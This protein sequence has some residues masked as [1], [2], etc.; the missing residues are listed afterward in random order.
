VLR[1]A[2]FRRHKK[3]VGRVFGPSDGPYFLRACPQLFAGAPAYIHPKPAALRRYFFVEPAVPVRRPGPKIPGACDSPSRGKGLRFLFGGDH[4]SPRDILR[5]FFP[6][7]PLPVPG[8][9]E[10]AD[11]FLECGPAAEIPRIVQGVVRIWLQPPDM[12]PPKIAPV[13]LVI[14]IHP[15][16][17]PHQLHRG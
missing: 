5:R 7:G 4:P 15:P 3:R 10:K 12:L 1:I 8:W 17:H 6:K 9:S 14:G 2:S 11:G 16:A 13:K